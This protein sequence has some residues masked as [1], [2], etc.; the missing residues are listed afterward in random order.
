MLNVANKVF[1]NRG[2]ILRKA[3]IDEFRNDIVSLRDTAN[4]VI[5]YKE[6]TW[7]GLSK[8]DCGRSVATSGTGC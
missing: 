2:W 8:T 7:R 6:G 1:D 3:F 4:P 5:F